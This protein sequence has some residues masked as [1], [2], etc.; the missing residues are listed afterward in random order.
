VQNRLFYGEALYASGQHAA[1]LAA[2]HEDLALARRQLGDEHLLVL[3]V[4]LSLARIAIAQGKAA[5]AEHELTDL[6]AALRKQGAPALI[7]LAQTLIAHA[8]ALL[9]QG[10]APQA[11]PLLNEALQTR[12]KLL[13]S[14]SW[15]LAEAHE[16]LGEALDATRDPRGKELLRR[17]A[18]VL[19]AQLGAQHP[20]TLRARRAAAL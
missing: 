17:A 18:A 19:E 13:W 1:G 5:L 6:Q 14:Q 15:E 4:R 20:F 12:E 8:D 2:L 16:R 11:I 3:R 9:A 7:A 10:R